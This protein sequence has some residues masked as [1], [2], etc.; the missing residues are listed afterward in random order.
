MIAPSAPDALRYVVKRAM[1]RHKIDRYPTA[2]EM[3]D[4]LQRF[5]DGEEPKVGSTDTKSLSIWE[6]FKQL[7]P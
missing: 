6:R 1:G 2:A 4:D 5:L 7:L 3:A